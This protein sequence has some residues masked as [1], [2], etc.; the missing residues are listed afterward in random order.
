MEYFFTETQKEIRDLARRFA[1]EKMK[2]VRA[3]LDRT[4]EFPFELM[5]GMADLGLMGVYFPEEYGGLGGGI[6]EMCIVVEELCRVDG[7]AGLCYAACGLGAFP[8]LIG[9]TDDQKK[10][11]MPRLAAGELAAFAI[12]EASAGSDS[13]NVKTRARRDGDYYVLNGTKQFITNGSVAKVYSVIASTNPSRGARGLSAFIIEDGTPGFTYG[14]IEDKMGIRCSKTAELVF[15]DCRVPAANL[16]GGK[17]GHGFIHTMRTFDRTRPGVGAQ[18]LGIAAGAL[19]EALEY[20][21]TRIQFD[22]P[23][24]SFQAVQMMLA[25]MAI[26]VEASRTLIYQAARAADAGARNTSAIASMAKVLA[27]DTAMRVTTDAVQILGGYGYMRDYPVEKM[28]RDAKITQIYEGT[29]Q[30]QRL[31]I[32]SELIKGTAW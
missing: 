27:S 2:P 1:Q 14:K 5:K 4:G 15:Q 18:A 19:D 17:E 28:M 21:R 24:A 29:N 3:E 16:I 8:I 7:A 31:V 13:S 12:T 26:Q 9:G 23:I 30:I 22:A 10:R 11:Y 6:M 20:A 32:A 25:D